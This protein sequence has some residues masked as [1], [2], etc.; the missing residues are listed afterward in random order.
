MALIVERCPRCGSSA[1]T[2]DVMAELF[3]S[4]SHDWV[5][6]Y[7]L[8]CI[9]RNCTRSTTF[10]V[11]LADYALRDNFK[12]SG[13]LVAFPDSIN[14]HFK[15]EGHISLRNFASVKSPE[16]VP[17][18]IQAAFREGATCFAVD[19]FNAAGTMFR[20]C[21]DLATRP[22]LPD[23][24]SVTDKLPNKKQRRDLGLRLAW[25]FENGLL[26]RDLGE[27]AKC[28]REDGN[29]G[30]HAGFLTLEDT[31]DLLDFT[32]ALLERLYTE[33]KR[34]ALAEERRVAR[35]AK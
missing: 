20:L 30:A 31:E 6:H 35:R 8:F 14:R 29:D 32:T 16:H 4:T 33:P 23:P 11:S 26:P 5:R 1:M 27:L 15:V 34:L 19:C 22:L 12:K 13:S 7:E 28:I 25:L 21:V 17:S 24:E 18:E 9:C 2:F 3:T 10:V